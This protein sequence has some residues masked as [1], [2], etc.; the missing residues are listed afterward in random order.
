[1]TTL[2]KFKKFINNLKEVAGKKLKYVF[3]KVRTFL[4][5]LGNTVSAI[6]TGMDVVKNVKDM[7]DGRRVNF[8]EILILTKNNVLQS[9]TKALPDEIKTIQGTLIC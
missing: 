7:N 6:I 5:N 2:N 4:G 8:K 1:M 3:G 9:I